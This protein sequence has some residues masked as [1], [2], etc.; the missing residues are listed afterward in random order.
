MEQF[1]RWYAALLQPSLELDANLRELARQI[2]ERNLTVQAKVQA[3]YEAV[4]RSTGYAAFEFGVHS[5]Q[6]Y[7]LALVDRRGFGDC[8]DKAAMIVALLRAVGVPAEFAMVRTRS[9]GE[10]SPDAYS[11]QLFNHAVAYV[12]AL[13]LF[14]DGT[15]EY[16]APGELPP[17][18]QGAIAFTVDADGKVTRRI[19][20][21]TSP[22]ASRVTRQ[23]Q[24]QALARRTPA[25][26]SPRPATPDI[27]PPSSAAPA[28]R[29]TTWPEARRPR[30][31]ASIPPSVSP[32]PSP[33]APR[34]PRAR[35]N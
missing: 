9:A 3:V 1:G 2:R 21:F 34:A 4:Q 25:S 31:P 11:V 24:A 19:V 15:V 17:D 10:I 30:W 35:W 13:D 20:P 8:K 29:P 33:K 18:D 32:T 26:S 14:L 27:L 5:Y 6:P 12:P 23:V 16:A 28:S 22:E 7:P